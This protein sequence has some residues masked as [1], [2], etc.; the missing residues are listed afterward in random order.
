MILLQ[1]VLQQAF[2]NPQELRGPD[3]DLV[4]LLQ[5]PADHLG[6]NLLQDL[7]CFGSRPG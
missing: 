7:R 1:L 3:L 6:L 4:G 2:G 5:G